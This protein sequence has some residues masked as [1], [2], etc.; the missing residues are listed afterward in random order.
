MSCVRTVS[1][2]VLIN[3]VPTDIFTPERGL[4]RGDPI[5]PFL[6]LFCAEAFSVLLKRAEMQCSIHGVKVAR[7]APTVSHLFFAD[8]T[9]LFTRATEKKA[10]EIK[11]LITSYELASGQRINLNKTEITVSSN[12]PTEVKEKLRDVLEVE[13]VE[14]HHK[15]LGLPTLIGKRKKEIFAGTVERILQKMKDWK[16]QSLSQAGREVLIKTILQAIPAYSMNCFLLPITTCQD[17]E[18]A[19]ARFFWGSTLEERKTHWAAWDILITTKANGGLGFR[20]LHMFNLAMLA[21]QL[22]ILL[23]N[24]GSLTHRILK[25]KYFPRKDIMEAGLGYKPSYL[26]RSLSAA[27]NW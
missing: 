7:S 13:A 9:I 23:Q 2:S 25:A 18:K 16:E 20:E 27:K 15:Y 3:R 4:R 14:Q 22:W 6:F 21:K 19:T 12:V 1:Y 17:I 24:T 26:W 10:R 11:Q 5:S 8:D